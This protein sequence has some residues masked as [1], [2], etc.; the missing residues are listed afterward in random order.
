M[1]TMC[2]NRVNGPLSN[3]SVLRYTFARFEE[4]K[5]IIVELVLPRQ[6]TTGSE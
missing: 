6:K 2:L 5:N 1:W 4:E 3:I